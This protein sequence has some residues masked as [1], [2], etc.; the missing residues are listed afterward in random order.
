MRLL[1]EHGI[2]VKN[3]MRYS[4]TCTAQFRSRHCNGDLKCLPEFLEIDGIISWRYY[5]AN[6]GKNQSDTVGALW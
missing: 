6:E 1:R 2:V 5:E 3:I 4:D